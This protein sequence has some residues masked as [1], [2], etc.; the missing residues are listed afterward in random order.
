[1]NEASLLK[2]I[3]IYQVIFKIEKYR[4]RLL[5]PHL[6]FIIIH[7]FFPKDRR[8]RDTSAVPT[9]TSL[10]LIPIVQKKA[11]MYHKQN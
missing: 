1:M 7:Y 6:S 3:T 10:T 4:T 5:A 2:H 11:Q 9:V 8:K